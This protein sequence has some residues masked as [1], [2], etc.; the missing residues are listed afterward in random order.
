MSEELINKFRPT[1]W[2]EVIGQKAEV[3]AL[4]E[5]I[6]NKRAASFLLSGPGGTGKTT[7]ARI[8]AHELGCDDQ[9][10]IEKDAATN[11]GVENM[12]EL[13][14]VLRYAPFGDSSRAVIIDEAHRLSG[15]AWDSLL[16][17]V[18]EPPKNTYWFFCT[19]NVAKVPNTIKTRCTH[20][21]LKPVPDK[22]LGVLYDR[23][24]EAEGFDPPG[25]VCDLIIKQAFG[26][27]RQML[28]N[29]ALCAHVEDRKE[30]ADLL[31]TAVET[32]PTLELCQALA[33]GGGSWVKVM[34]IVGRITDEPEGVRILV[35][36]Y[37][38]KALAG[39]KTEKDAMF[40]LN[41]LDCFSK[42]YNPA[43]GRAPLLLSIGSA[44][45]G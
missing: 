5:I 7:L 20:I 19:T 40:F 44:M 3:K 39:A 34:G 41:V 6:E 23:V 15:N 30:A 18:E 38:G 12:R 27:P 1:T 31:K 17:S 36:N 8:A 37:M 13:Q 33:K 4:R 45:L 43:E 21:Q 22:T 14:E 42:P 10:I 25:D 26:S 35:V 11:T 28:T 2:D 32:Q 29:L 16:K 24:C 9:N